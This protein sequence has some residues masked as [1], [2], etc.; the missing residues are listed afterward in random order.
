VVF[1]QQRTALPGSLNPLQPG[2]NTPFQNQLATRQSLLQF[3]LPGAWV[4]TALVV[5]VREG[6]E[7]KRMVIAF[8]AVGQFA[9][10]ALVLLSFI[11]HQHH[12]EIKLLNSAGETE[13]TTDGLIQFKYSG[14]PQLIRQYY[15][16]FNQKNRLLPGDP[17][18]LFGRQPRFQ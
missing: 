17:F 12:I 6:P 8:L 2:S 1:S 11:H 18:Q 16:R 13:R 5:E 14:C 9:I 7:I 10:P 4:G 3:P 15:V